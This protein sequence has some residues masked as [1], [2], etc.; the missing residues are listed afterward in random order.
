MNITVKPRLLDIL[1]QR[2]MTQKQL[3]D[4]AGITQ[5]AVSRFSKNNR[6]EITHLFAIA[7]ALS[8]SIEDLFEVEDV[9]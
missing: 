6:Y 1:D 4:K 9:K 2:N 3:A 7:R 8:V 5:A